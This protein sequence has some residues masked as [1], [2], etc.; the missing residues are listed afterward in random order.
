MLSRFILLVVS[1]IR[2]RNTASKS[3]ISQISPILLS[4][5][6]PIFSPDFEMADRRGKTKYAK[7]AGQI[8]MSILLH[9]AS[10]Y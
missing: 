1:L 7:V 5:I 10:N 4:S 8:S 6:D 3:E 2:L 9:T